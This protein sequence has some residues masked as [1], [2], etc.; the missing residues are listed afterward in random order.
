MHVPPTLCGV[1]FRVVLHLCIS[2]GKGVGVV[3]EGP[4]CT[5]R[6]CPA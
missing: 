4:P 2:M 6:E 1:L 5:V 3:F